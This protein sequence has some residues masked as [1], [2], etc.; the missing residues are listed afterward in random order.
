MKQ[1]EEQ[2]HLLPLVVELR[3]DHPRMSAREMYR[4]IKPQQI[5]RDRFINFC[6]EHGYKV[7]KK[8]SFHRTTDS[9]GV[10]RFPNLITDREFTGVNQAWVSD[11]TYYRMGEI[12]YYLTFIMDMFSRTIVGYSVSD[13]LMTEYTTLSA[14]KMAISKRHLSQGLILHSDGGGQYYSKTFTALTQRYKMKNSMCES[15]YENPHAERING[16]I[17]NDYIIPY[18]P[19]DFKDLKEKMQKAVNM[20]NQY[21]PH[22]SL[23]G[24]TPLM[25]ETILVQ[26][27]LLNRGKKEKSSIVITKLNKTQKTVNAI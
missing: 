23:N 9:S 11:I 7:E 16:T 18:G 2:Y 12:F 4:L 26:N 19:K 27:Q 21:R 20:Y 6:F 5:G 15:V 1:M 24:M 17:K 25:F 13:N 3:Q 10:I 14:L 22:K 8:R